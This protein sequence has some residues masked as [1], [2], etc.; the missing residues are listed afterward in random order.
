LDDEPFDHLEETV[1]S[2]RKDRTIDSRTAQVDALLSDLGFFAIGQYLEIVF[3]TTGFDYFSESRPYESMLLST[4]G[5]S[6]NLLVLVVFL[7]KHNIV[8]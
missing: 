7:T 8:P 3:E 4:G 5:H 1:S 2:T 6:C